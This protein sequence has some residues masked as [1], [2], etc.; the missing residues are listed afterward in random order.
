MHFSAASI[1]AETSPVKAP[2]ASECTFCAASTYE[3]RSA[4]SSVCTDR[5]A[6]N[7]GQ[8]TT[9]TRS[10]SSSSTRY[11]SFWT[12]WIASRCVLCIFQ[13][14]AMIGRRAVPAIYASS[15]RAAMPG[16]SRPSMNSSEAPPPV[17]R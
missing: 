10:A 6:V 7:G 11:E 5:S 4:S 3:R 8:M 14:A 2:F 9:S 17:E 16:S 15:M 1:S 12:A 13:L